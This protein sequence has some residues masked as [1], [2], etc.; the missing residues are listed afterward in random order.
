MKRFSYS[1]VCLMMIAAGCGDTA[2]KSSTPSKDEIRNGSN[3]SSGGDGTDYCDLYG[4]Y[5]D[6]TC[7]DFCDQEDPDC[8]LDQCAAYPVCPAG[9]NE[10]QICDV[11]GANCI[12]ATECG[13]TI[14]CQI[15][16]EMCVGEPASCDPGYEFVNSCSGY[17]DCYSQHDVCGNYFGCALIPVCTQAVAC[18]AGT[19]EIDSCDEVSPSCVEL[20][21]SCGGSTFC[22]RNEACEAFPSCSPDTRE[23]EFCDTSKSYCSTSSICGYTVYCIPDL[24]CD[25][26]PF[27][28]DDEVTYQSRTDCADDEPCREEAVCSEIIY[29]AP[30]GSCET[31]TCTN[32]LQRVAQCDPNVE[33]CETLK[34]CGEEIYCQ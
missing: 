24:D 31:P 4:W 23:V 29:C 9:Y 7:D 13:T 28:Q 19:L 32:G 25:A 27:C 22:Q 14:K 11:D 30:S 21:N 10:S 16:D 6:G 34:G 15:E 3:N 2:L 8:L 17:A 5:D 33:V 12:L 26:V 20:L 1:I 18:P